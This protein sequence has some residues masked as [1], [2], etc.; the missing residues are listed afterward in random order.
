M[1][2]DILTSE[3]AQAVLNKDFTNIVR[4]AKDGKTLSAQERTILQ[5]IASSEN[6]EEEPVD[7]RAQARNLTELAK[8]L[9]CSRPTLNQWRKMEGSPQPNSDSTWE[10]DNWRA[11]MKDNDLSGRKTAPEGPGA[12]ELKA[13]K[14]LVEIEL[15][16]E[17][18]AVERQ[19]NIPVEMVREFYGTKCAEVTSLLQNKLC[20]E[21]PQ[22]VAGLDVIEIKERCQEVVDEIIEALNR[23]EI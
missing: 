12:D 2:G 17:K 23:G 20:G 14:L 15:K 7:A 8:I 5:Q 19:Q 1:M 6:P 9:G 11:F 16:E 21:L 3:Q 4:K 10:V 13:R 22:A 18:L